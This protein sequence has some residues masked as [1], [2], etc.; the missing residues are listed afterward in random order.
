MARQQQQQQQNYS[1]RTICLHFM[2]NMLFDLMNGERTMFG[3]DNS[4]T[5]IAR[6]ERKKQPKQSKQTEK[7]RHQQHWIKHWNT[8]CAAVLK[9]KMSGWLMV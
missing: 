7:E 4:R 8:R 9:V 6:V 2:Q 1:V 5:K 3:D